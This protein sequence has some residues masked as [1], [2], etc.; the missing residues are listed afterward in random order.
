MKR[1]IFL[2][3]ALALVGVACNRQPEAQPAPGQ[4]SDG[5]IQLAGRSISYEL[6]GDPAR[7]QR[8]LSGRQSI[9]ENQGM[10]FPFQAPDFLAFWMKDMNF[11][12]DIVWLKGDEIVDISADI[13]PQ[14]GVPDSELRTYS[15]KVPAN[16][17]LELKAGWASRNGLKIGDRI[18][19]TQVVR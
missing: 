2:A 9:E 8:G 19:I 12:I 10:L 7:Q 16:G 3:L 13:Q 5:T 17:V 6:A 11:A 15:P 14:P 18:E 4:Y 1:I